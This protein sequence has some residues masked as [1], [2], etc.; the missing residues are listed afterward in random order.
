MP[1][2]LPTYVTKSAARRTVR[3]IDLESSG[4]WTS[5]RSE[6]DSRHRARGRRGRGGDEEGR[7]RRERSGR[8][9]R[10][11]RGRR[12]LARHSHSSARPAL[13]RIR[14]SPR[15]GVN[16]LPRRSVGVPAIFRGCGAVGSASRSHR[17]GQG[18]ESPQLHRLCRSERFLGP[19][20]R[21][22]V[23]RKSTLTRPREAFFGPS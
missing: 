21:V 8:V 9:G 17:E 3:S 15:P 2:T 7:G 22:E 11:E 18:F 23:H 13:W 12:L 1:V 10:P 20:G 6:I 4:V 16:V 14:S 19:G 5:G